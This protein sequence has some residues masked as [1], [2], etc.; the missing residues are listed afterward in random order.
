M[1]HRCSRRIMT[2]LS[3]RLFRQ[4][5]LVATG[6]IRNVSRH[7]VFVETDYCEANKNQAFDLE[8]SSLNEHL[9]MVSA[10]IAYQAISGFGLEFLEEQNSL[11]QRCSLLTP[12]CVTRLKGLR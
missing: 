12:V 9:A 4:G 7:G 10:T 8:I 3:T 1:E 2:C 5:L 11:H 6:V